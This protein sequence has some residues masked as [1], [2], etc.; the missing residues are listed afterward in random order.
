M[1]RSADLKSAGLGAFC[2]ALLRFPGRPRS[3]LRC[4]EVRSE[5][6]SITPRRM[7]QRGIANRKA[8]ILEPARHPK[9][10]GVAQMTSNKAVEAAAIASVLE[11][12]RASEEPTGQ[13]RSVGPPLGPGS[14]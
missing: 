11:I 9:A 8:P 3:L 14:A 12:E 2:T 5:S 7:V 10:T 1:R 6:A 4:L 13:R